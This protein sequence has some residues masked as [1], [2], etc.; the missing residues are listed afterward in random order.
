MAQHNVVFEGVDDDAIIAECAG[1][2]TDTGSVQVEA[3][4]YTYYC[5]IP[6]HREAGMEGELTVN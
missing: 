6:G 2:E 1:G 4:S 3:G 5:S